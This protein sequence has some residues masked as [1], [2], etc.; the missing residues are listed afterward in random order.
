MNNKVLRYF[1]AA[2]FTLFI[3]S[4]GEVTY[5]TSVVTNQGFPTIYMLFLFSIILLVNY[6]ILF[7]SYEE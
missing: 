5:K 2:S 1:G 3:L 7:A 4:M 6:V